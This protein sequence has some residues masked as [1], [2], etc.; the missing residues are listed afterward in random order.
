MMNSQV[1]AQID[2]INRAWTV[3]GKNKGLLESIG[4]MFHT[5]TLDYNVKLVKNYADATGQG[6]GYPITVDVTISDIMLGFK[7]PLS[8]IKQNVQ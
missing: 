8:Q 5:G 2:V 1:A 3:D 6:E 4:I 7:A